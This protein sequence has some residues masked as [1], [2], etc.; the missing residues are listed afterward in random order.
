MTVSPFVLSP[1]VITALK[2]TPISRGEL[3]LPEALNTLAKTDIVICPPLTKGHYA[4]TGDPLNWLKVNIE[5]A[6]RNPLYRS[7]ILDM[8]KSDTNTKLV[9]DLVK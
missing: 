5:L 1:K 6:L 8:L 2:N 7:E 4:T 9:S 3:W